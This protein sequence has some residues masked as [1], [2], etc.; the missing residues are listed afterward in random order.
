[1]IEGNDRA[2]IR[3]LMFDLGGV[4]IEVD[5]GR[6]MRAWAAAAGCDPVV[7]GQRFTFDEAYR[8]HE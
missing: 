4:L 3:A 8:Q 1:M 6:V 7:L 2:A 5:F